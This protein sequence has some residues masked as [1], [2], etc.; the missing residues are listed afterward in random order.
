MYGV[1]HFIKCIRNVRVYLLSCFLCP[2][3][4]AF[5]VPSAE[6]FEDVQP[7]SVTELSL[8]MVAC[9]KVTGKCWGRKGGVMMVT[10]CTGACTGGGKNI[11][12]LKDSQMS[13]IKTREGKKVEREKE[14]AL[15]CDSSSFKYG[16][17]SFDFSLTVNI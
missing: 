5:P 12:L 9:Q 11:T 2:N 17:C 15:G 13:E 6:K 8:L 3:A 1:D 4:P 7:P 10:T 14:K 16:L